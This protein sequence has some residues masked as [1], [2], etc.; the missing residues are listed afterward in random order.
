[1]SKKKFFHNR[2]C[3]EKKEVNHNKPRKKSYHHLN[4]RSRM[5]KLMKDLGIINPSNS[6]I[7]MIYGKKLIWDDIH[8]AWHALFS[9]FLA[10]EAIEQIKLWSDDELKSIKIYLKFKQRLAW[11]KIF[12][13]NASPREAI[14]IIKRDWAPEFPDVEF[15]LKRNK[16]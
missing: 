4:P 12:G 16:K 9:N 10:W 1:M 15:M 11:N 8:N 14:G 2:Y 13:K 5:S 7:K 6:F 3:R